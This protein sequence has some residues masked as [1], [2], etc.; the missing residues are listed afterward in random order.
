MLERF[1]KASFRAPGLAAGHH[2]CNRESVLRPPAARGPASCQY[3]ALGGRRE[4]L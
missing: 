3:L 1:G 4:R 2:L